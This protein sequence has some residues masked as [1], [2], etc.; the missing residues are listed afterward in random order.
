MLKRIAVPVQLQQFLILLVLLIAGKLGAFVFLSW[1]EIALLLGAGLLIEHLLLLLKTRSHRLHYFSFSVLSTT[2]GI[3]MM[4]ATPHWWIYLSAL[5]LALLQKHFLTLQD[6][7]LFNPSNFALIV[8]MVL[9]YQ[10]AH[11]V[12]GQLGDAWW[13][14]LL[15]LVLGATILLRVDRWVISLSFIV[16]YL[17]FS[18]L[19]VVRYDPVMLFEDVYGRFY[20]VSFIL[21]VLFMLTDP[22]TTPQSRWGQ[23]VFGAGVALG[24]VLLDRWYGFR[25]Q[26]LFMVL[27][28]LT[29]LYVLWVQA[30]HQPRTLWLGV[31]VLLLALG[32][33]IYLEIQPPYY[34]AMDM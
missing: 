27:F 7:H 11:V 9:F 31:A 4:L 19:W 34:F 2:L 16:A 10:Q 17:L 22:R 1:G 21:F 26:H 30:R 33:I 13:L 29:P 28:V 18:Y 6:R 20:A 12:M 3:V 14:H 5:F 8:A 24:A 23:L 25:A 15:L 32:A